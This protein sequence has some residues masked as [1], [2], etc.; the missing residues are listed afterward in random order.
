MLVWFSLTFSTMSFTY[1][2]KQWCQNNALRNTRTYG[3][4][5][6]FATMYNY[7]ARDYIVN[8]LSNFETQ[9]IFKDARL[10]SK[11]WR[12]QYQ[13][14]WTKMECLLVYCCLDLLSPLNTEKSQKSL[15]EGQICPTHRHAQAYCKGSRE[16]SGWPFTA[17]ITCHWGCFCFEVV[18]R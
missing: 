15:T 2:K 6:V 14:F 10:I 12:V 3:Y 9:W 16:P 11:S 18:H 4:G 1:P 5:R 13:M 17:P 8:F 7:T